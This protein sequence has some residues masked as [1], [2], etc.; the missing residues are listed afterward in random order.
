MCC[1]ADN[2]NY[3]CHTCAKEFLDAIFKIKAFIEKISNFN[4]DYPNFHIFTKNHTF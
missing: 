3:K 1:A 2:Y 4:E